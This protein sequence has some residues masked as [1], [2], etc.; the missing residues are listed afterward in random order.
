VCGGGGREGLLSPLILATK[1]PDEMGPDE[2]RISGRNPPIQ[3]AELML[4][5]HKLKG[6]NNN[7][8]KRQRDGFM[9]CND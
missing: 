5:Q 4:N 1:Y 3:T 2:A 6:G 7:N 9:N 8:N